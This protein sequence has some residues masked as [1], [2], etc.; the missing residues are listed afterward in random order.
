MNK[1][2]ISS[3]FYPGIGGIEN[4][5]KNIT[6]SLSDM[7][8]DCETVSFSKPEI[9][10]IKKKHH[11]IERAGVYKILKYL[12]SGE[13]ASLLYAVLYI[14]RNFSNDLFFISRHPLF[15]FAGVILN[16]K[17]HVY[18]PPAVM[19]DFYRGV[20]NDI[21]FR[22]K[23]LLYFKYQIVSKIHRFYECKVVTNENVTVCT[24]SH[25][26]KHQF[27]NKY[28]KNSFISEPGVDHSVFKFEQNFE[29]DGKVKFLYVG[30]LEPGKNVELLLTAFESN[31]DSNCRLY[32]VGSGTLETELKSR[33]QDDN[34]I[35]LGT[36]VKDE[37]SKLYSQADFT[38]LPTYYE[39][40]GQVLIESLCCGTKVIGFDS[41]ISN[42][43]I[44]QI[45]KDDN[46]GFPIMKLGE[47]GITSVLIR[48]KNEKLYK[49]DKSYVS[50]ISALRFSWEK[51]CNELI[52]IKFRG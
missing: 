35:F 23:P 10:S 16:F 43:A 52:N 30:R 4:S 39:G 17:N 38:I 41:S 15:A 14:N 9:F 37:L 20:L 11:F 36:K 45:I 8:I 5:I 33:Y 28:K 40:F 25:N 27:L 1:I 6:S 31:C 42:T 7:G 49:Y 22:D 32:I 50:K 2:L 12:L 46:Y 29:S 13:I 47:S 26:I 3:M 18:I 51:F 34:I 19:E 24:F 44:T 21:R 48:I